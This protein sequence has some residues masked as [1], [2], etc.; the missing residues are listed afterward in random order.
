[1]SAWTTFGST[2]NTTLVAELI[3][4]C[5]G[6]WDRQLGAGDPMCLAASAC[7]AYDL[8]VLGRALPM[9]PEV[10]RRSG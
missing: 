8:S 7:L 3:C 5:R 10:R 1:M 4:E 2:K 6:S 9:L